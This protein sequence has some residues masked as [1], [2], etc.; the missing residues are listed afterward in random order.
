MEV[1]SSNAK[2]KTFY[3]LFGMGS[4]TSVNF[5]VGDLFLNKVFFFL[6][7]REY[8]FPKFES[9]NSYPITLI[10]NSSL[11]KTFSYAYF[12]LIV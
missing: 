8:I 2:I 1:A 7:P 9:L 10:F 11:L 4:L 3:I 5:T 12:Q 6:R